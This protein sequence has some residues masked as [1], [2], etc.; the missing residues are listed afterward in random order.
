MPHTFQEFFAIATSKAAADLVEAMLRLPVDKRSWS[1]MGN[2][3]SA[4]NQV[5]EC[6]L[7]NGRMASMVVTRPSKLSFDYEEFCRRRDELATDWEAV[8]TLLAENT[9][10]LIEAIRALTDADLDIELPMRSGPMTI[11]NI[12]EVP[13]WNMS[14]HEGQINYIASM[15]GCLD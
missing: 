12:I 11:A 14:Y 2:A 5:A 15:L 4:L 3:R 7:L 6:A 9:A 10:K 1:P 13:Y 8:R